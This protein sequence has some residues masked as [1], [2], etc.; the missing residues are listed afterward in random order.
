[1]REKTLSD[2]IVEQ[3]A[4]T[5]AGMKCG[6][7][8]NYHHRESADAGRE[9]SGWNERLNPCGLYV[10]A[11]NWREDSVLVY[12][13][14]KKDLDQR[15]REEGIAELLSDFGYP[16]TETGECLCHLKNRLL[17][18][19]F[20]HEIGVFL[21]YPLGDVLGFIENRGRN[22]RLCGMWKVYCDQCGALK[23]F[24]KYKKCKE[25]YWKLYQQGRGILKMTVAA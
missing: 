14:R 18:D 10:E 23:L 8:F 1:M 7:L 12:V 21:D 11:L 25:V 4:P 24:K 9:I 17:K 5:L 6:S 3:C 13:Y 16:G 15:L 20:P 22:C 2:L 19:D